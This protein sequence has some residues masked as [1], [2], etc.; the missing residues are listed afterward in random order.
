MSA[1]G[2]NFRYFRDLFIRA[3]ICPCDPTAGDSCPLCDGQAAEER[4]QRT[5]DR[6]KN[7]RAA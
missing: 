6:D 7:R 1:S 2:V 5:A 3:R 4:E